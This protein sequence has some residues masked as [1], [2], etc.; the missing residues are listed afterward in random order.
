MKP[1]SQPSKKKILII[2]D[3]IEGISLKKALTTAKTFFEA[4]RDPDSEIREE[5]DNFLNKHQNQFQNK[6]ETDGTVHEAFFKEVILSDSFKNSLSTVSLTY[7]SL[8]SLY[9]ENEWL[10]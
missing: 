2:D 7:K 9:Q 10:L 8:S 6:L 1:T 5:M 4:L 3:E